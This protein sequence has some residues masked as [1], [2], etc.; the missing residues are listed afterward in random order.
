[1][2]TFIC[3]TLPS[4]TP[5]QTPVH[6]QRT[7][8]VIISC[9]RLYVSYHHHANPCIINAR[10]VLSSRSDIHVCHITIIHTRAS[11]THVQCHRL[12]QTFMCVISPSY[13]RVHHHRT[14]STIV[15]FRHSCVSYHHHTHP[16]IINARP[17]PS[18]R[19]HVCH[20]TIIH[21]IIIKVRLACL[22]SPLM[23]RHHRSPNVLS[24]SGGE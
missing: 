18:S 20:I 10:P 17:V 11:S 8:S 14:S 5:S 9:R 13:T 2:Q 15:S 1:M 23:S 19:M 24:F 6:H 12:V 21:T 16:C 7:S 4:L 22:V 3:V